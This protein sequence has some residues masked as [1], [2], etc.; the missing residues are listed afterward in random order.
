M[1]LVI[2]LE[3]RTVNGSTKGDGTNYRRYG[4][5]WSR[6]RG[7]WVWARTIRPETIIQRVAMMRCDL[8]VSEVIGEAGAVD[9]D[10]DERDRAILARHERRHEAAAAEADARYAA[11]KTTMNMIPMG[12]PIL[13]GHHSEGRHRRD[14][15]RMDANMR[16]SIEADRQ[17]KEHDRLADE[18]ERR[19]EHRAAVRAAEPVPVEMIQPGDEVIRLTA[20]RRRSY[21]VHKVNR[22]T[23]AWA[24]QGCSGSWKHAEAVELHRDG[25][26]LWPLTESG[27]VAP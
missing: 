15:A 13:I 27:E 11:V 3:Q 18:A 5:V 17:A 6:R 12:Q 9:I 22:T 1:S 16:K 10:A 8:D 7:C 26:Q 21:T 20:A 23:I 14:V 24:W 25:V 2:D 19:I 4:L